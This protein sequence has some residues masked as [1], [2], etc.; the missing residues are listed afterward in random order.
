L[1]FLTNAYRYK[2]YEREMDPRQDCSPPLTQGQL[3]NLTALKK[4]TQLTRKRIVYYTAF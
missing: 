4:K 2:N 3:V 1:S